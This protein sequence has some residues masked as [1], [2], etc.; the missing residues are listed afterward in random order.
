ME[1]RSIEFNNPCERLIHRIRRWFH[2]PGVQVALVLL[3]G[4]FWGLLLAPTQGY[5]SDVGNFQ[6]WSFWLSKGSILQFYANNAWCDY[7]PGYLYVLCIVGRLYEFFCGGEFNPTDPGFHY[8][9]KLTSII[10]DIFIGWLIYLFVRK[11]AKHRLALLACAA[12][13]FNPAVILNDAVWGDADSFP[14]ALM[15]GSYTSLAVG[16]WMISSVLLGIACITKPQVALSLVAFG[17]LLLMKFPPKVWWRYI[18]I[19]SGTA[20]LGWFPFVFSLGTRTPQWIYDRYQSLAN[21]YPFGS[22]N[23]FNIWAF[24]GFFQPDSNHVLGLSVFAWGQVFFALTIILII[25]ITVHRRTSFSIFKLAFL[26]IFSGFLFWTRMHERYCYYALPFALVA[27]FE[28]GSN[29]WKIVY[30][31]LSATA[32]LNLLYVLYF[33]YGSPST[34]VFFDFVDRIFRGQILVLTL[35]FANALFFLTSFFSYTSDTDFPEQTYRFLRK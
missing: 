7:Q 15:L 12:F 27:S 25:I 10:P 4:S 24:S 9:V 32:F 11:N 31:G 3:L 34:Y 26:V 19:T 17:V 1:N 33:A 35:S 21:E 14:L 5:E 30:G 28:R 20:A 23:A 13:V 29:L 2:R 6:S 16:R 22:L 18:V 8:V